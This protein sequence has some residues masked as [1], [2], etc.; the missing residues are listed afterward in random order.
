MQKV[1]R[2]LTTRFQQRR[3]AIQYN[4]KSLKLSFKSIWNIR[5]CQSRG[6][7]MLL[8]FV[9][10]FLV[11]RTYVLNIFSRRH[12]QTA[13]AKSGHLLDWLYNYIENTDTYC[14]F[15]FFIPNE[16]IQREFKFKFRSRNNTCALKTWNIFEKAIHMNSIFK[17]PQSFWTSC[18]TTRSIS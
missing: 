14:C 8:I 16:Y 7:Y 9:C 17:Y 2:H 10:E 5:S 13:P 1:N 11:W 3:H 4:Q 6:M 18:S 15:I 12:F